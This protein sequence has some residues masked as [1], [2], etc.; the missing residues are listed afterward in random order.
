MRIAIKKMRHSG[1]FSP[2]SSFL[3]AEEGQGRE[4]G[5]LHPNWHLHKNNDWVQVSFNFFT[6]NEF[7]M[8]GSCI[9]CEIS[10][11]NV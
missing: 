6:T 8:R 2:F 10:P 11:M 4:K 9:C 1:I 5:L 3:G 7:T